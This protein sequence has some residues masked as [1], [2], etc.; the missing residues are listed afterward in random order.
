MV[1]IDI[2]R[3]LKRVSGIL[4]DIEALDLPW[5]EQEMAGFDWFLAVGGVKRLLAAT[6]E[7]DEDQKTQFS[8]LR[9]RMAAVGDKLTALDLEN[10]FAA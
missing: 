4:S 6:A 8:T 2:V 9:A 7:M 3:E 5:N 10:P 1:E